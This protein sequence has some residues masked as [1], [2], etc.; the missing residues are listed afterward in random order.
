MQ[1]FEDKVDLIEEK[2][3]KSRRDKNANLPDNWSVT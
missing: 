2:L 1:L 3:E